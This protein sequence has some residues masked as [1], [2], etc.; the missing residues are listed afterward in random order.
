MIETSVD[1]TLAR[2]E[3]IYR[4]NV[5]RVHGFAHARVGTDEAVDV[6]S[7]VFHAAAVAAREGR[8][9]QVTTAWLMAVTRNKVHDHWRR[10]YRRKARAHLTHA[11]G[12]DLMDF[13]PDWS[14]DPRRAEVLA[15]L[16]QLP[17]RDRSLLVLHHV[18]GMSTAELA[19]SADK[20][21]AA[22]ES[23]LA[24]AR[25]RFRTH[26]RSDGD[27]AEIERPR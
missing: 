18:D 6:V 27:G 9:D 14:T 25:R 19:A 1:T 22:I 20:S 21:V 13:P 8:I 10:A 23:A 26:Y 17:P 15:A 3:R 24:R 7:E 16:D 11:R 12:D 4:D 2:L 5:R